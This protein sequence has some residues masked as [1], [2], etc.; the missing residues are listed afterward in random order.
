[1]FNEKSDFLMAETEKLNERVNSD[2]A[3]LAQT[4]EEIE[5]FEADDAR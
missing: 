4:S 5:K 2:Q 3:K 1:V